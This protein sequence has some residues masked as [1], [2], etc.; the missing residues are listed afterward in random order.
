MVGMRD[1]DDVM[2]ELS[3]ML[4]YKYTDISWEFPI[5]YYQSLA[6]IGSLI[7]HLN[8]G[9]MHESF[10]NPATLIHIHQYKEGKQQI[11]DLSH[12]MIF[13]EPYLDRILEFLRMAPIEVD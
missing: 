4:G 6:P 8:I 3:D 13:E 1:I 2:N 9:V 12:N 10:I 7:M 11:V 5:Q